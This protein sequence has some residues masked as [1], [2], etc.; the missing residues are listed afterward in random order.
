MRV[1]VLALMVVSLGGCAKQVGPRVAGTD[2]DRLDAVSARLEE[3]RLRAREEGLS[4]G[5]RCDNASDT[6]E[7]AE[8]LCEVGARQPDREDVAA[9]CTE[10]REQCAQANN[11]CTRCRAD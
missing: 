11:T 6:C 9:R 7:A 10:A 5:A 3:L 8:E 2:A 4:C 1:L